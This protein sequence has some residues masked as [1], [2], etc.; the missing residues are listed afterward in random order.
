M[1]CRH[2]IFSFVRNWRPIS[3]GALLFPVRRHCRA[4]EHPDKFGCAFSNWRGSD[5]FHRAKLLFFR[6]STTPHWTS[7]RG[8]DLYAWSLHWCGIVRLGVST[9][10]GD[11]TAD[12]ARAKRELRFVLHRT[13]V[14]INSYP[15]A[16]FD[17]PIVLREVSC[18]VGPV[19]RVQRESAEVGDASRRWPGTNV[20]GAK[21]MLSDKCA[22]SLGELCGTKEFSRHFCSHLASRRYR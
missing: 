14:W 1:E 11:A 16:P 21:L 18:G 17:N 3:G 7:R 13:F 10:A 2:V 9:A 12:V 4:C 20:S 6:N 22:E 5:T 8:C 19:L 15:I